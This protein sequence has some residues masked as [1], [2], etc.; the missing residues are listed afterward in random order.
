MQSFD[1]VVLGAGETGTRIANELSRQNLK[2]ALIAMPGH[3]QDYLQRLIEAVSAP[4][5]QASNPSR[6]VPAAVTLISAN[7]PPRFADERHLL[8]D[9]EKIQFKNAVLATGCVPRPVADARNPVTPVDYFNAPPQSSTVNVW[10]AGAVG[11][12]AAM[13][14]AGLGGLVRLISKHER[15]LPSE[16]VATSEFVAQQLRRAGVQIV[17]DTEAETAATFDLLCAGLKSQSDDLD[18]RAA[19]IYADPATGAVKT[20]ELMR[21]SNPRVYAAGAVT[22]PPFHLSF[23]RFQS[24]LIAENITASVFMQHRCMPEAFPST[25]PFPTPLARIGLTEQEA[26]AKFKDAA[27]ITQTFGSG[28]VKLVGRK[29]SA[30]L[31][32]AHA[33]GAGADG[34]ILFFDLMMRAEITL[35]DVAERHH[36]PTSPISNAAADAVERWITLAGR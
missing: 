21:T 12:C 5:N 22:G 15:V 17:A 23:E 3:H 31:L 9:G 8:V 14:I 4:A 27:A 36:F 7:A 19:L 29:R 20:D 26:T 11:V 35:R 34:L 24:D 25:I 32:G 1:V 18:L 13:K 16:D 10:G 30:L 33:A 28:F 2:T 6:P